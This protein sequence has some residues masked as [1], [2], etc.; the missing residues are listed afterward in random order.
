MIGRC[1]WSKHH[2][3]LYYWLHCPQ[4]CVV[5]FLPRTNSGHWSPDSFCYW[6][7]SSITSVFDEDLGSASYWTET[8]RA[9]ISNRRR[10]VLLL[11]TLRTTRT[12]C[13]LVF[14]EEDDWLGWPCVNYVCDGRVSSTAPASST[15][16]IPLGTMFQVCLRHRVVEAEMNLWLRTMPVLEKYYLIKQFSN[17]ADV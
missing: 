7:F 16:W 2:T 13:S 3:T 4:H 11:L 8:P 9:L 14:P 6:L 10:M 17:K 15:N 5:G 12:S 1:M